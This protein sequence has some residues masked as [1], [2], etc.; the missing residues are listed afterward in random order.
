MNFREAEDQ[1]KRLR[2]DLDARR[3]GP[4]QFEAA[5]A[6]LRVEDEQGRWWQVDPAQ[7][8][9]LLWDGSR[10]TAAAPPAAPPPVPGLQG[11]AIPASSTQA[12]P[13]PAPVAPLVQAFRDGDGRATVLRANLK[14]R[15]LTPE[16]FRQ[17]LSEVRIQDA[18]GRTWQPD[19]AQ[20]GWLVW[21]G[22]QWLSAVPP[23]PQAGS[24]LANLQKK[25]M[26]PRTFLDVARRVPL[27]QR[28]QGWWDLL[29]ILAGMG[30]GW[31]WFV[32]GSVRGFPYPAFMSSIRREQWTDF[33]PALA[34]LM[35]P[36]VL[37]LARRAI[38]KL[39][40]PIFLKLQT[41]PLPARLALGLCAGGVLWLFTSPNMLLSRFINFREGLDW[42]TPVL[43]TAMPMAF[44]LLRKELDQALMPFQAFKR[45]I[46]K[47]V[48]LGIGIALPFLTAWVMY[49]LLGISQY[50]LLRMNTVVGLVLSY[51]VVRTPQAWPGGARP[52]RSTVATV[53]ILLLI[54]AAASTP[55]FADDFL[56]DPFNLQDGLRTDGVAPVLAGISTAGGLRLRERRGGH[57]G[58]DPVRHTRGRGRGGGAQAVHRAGAHHRQGRR[59]LH[60]PGHGERRDLPLRP[61]RG[62]RQGPVP[63]PGTPRSSSPSP[64]RTAGSPCRIWAPSTASGARWCARPRPSPADRPRPPAWS[65]SRPERAPAPPSPCPSPSPAWRSAG[66]WSRRSTTSS[67]GSPCPA[68]R[69]RK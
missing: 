64:R 51:C 10:W 54:F 33:I 35:V 25:L 69:T 2:Q 22:A 44:V 38:A 21:D 24:P 55:G 26:D 23:I 34:L 29:G 4:A 18:Q 60:Q 49:R 27:G 63:P 30:S 13:I 20:P 1:W 68:S 37:F 52:S 11:P 41:I 15:Q 46:P 36:L 6:Q 50:P 14:A 7:G 47:L 53:V 9:W 42:I 43:M 66:P 12:P 5:A 31:L 8:S 65:R 28:P 48:L 61:L 40:S 39:I 16:A 17:A 58:H 56:R 59:P 3:I 67:G 19:P 45:H 57:P 62:G 32:Y